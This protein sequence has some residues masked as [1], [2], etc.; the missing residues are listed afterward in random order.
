MKFFSSVKEV[1]CFHFR[2]FR[3][4]LTLSLILSVIILL[5]KN[6]IVKSLFEIPLFFILLAGF[7]PRNFKKIFMILEVSSPDTTYKRTGFRHF[8]NLCYLSGTHF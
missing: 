8:L 2:K 5:Y 4:L 6:H 7:I 1:N 3:N